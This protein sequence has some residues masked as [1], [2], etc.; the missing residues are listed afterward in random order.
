MS[1]VT[2]HVVHTLMAAAAGIA[3]TMASLIGGTSAAS[4]GFKFKTVVDTSTAVPRG[5]GALFG[6]TLGSAPAVSGNNVVFTANNEEIWTASTTGRGLVRVISPNMRIPGGHGATFHQDYGTFVQVHGD[7]VV[8]V[9]LDCSLCNSGM[10]LYAVPVAG[11]TVKRLVDVNLARPDNPEQNFGRFGDDFDA[12]GAHVVFAN[13]GGVYA[14]RVVGGR[15]NVVTDVANCTLGDY[16]GFGLPTLDSLDSE[17][18]LKASNGLS[19]GRIELARRAG[20][21]ITIVADGAMHPPNTPRAYRFDEFFGSFD[22]P[23]IDRSADHNNRVFKGESA[24]AS[25]PRIYGIYNF[26]SAGHIGLV[27]STTPVPG[28]TGAFSGSGFVGPGARSLAAGNGIVI[29]RGI[30]ATGKLG[31]YAV[32]ASGGAITK[33][34]AQGDPIN[35]TTVDTAEPQSLVF[36]REGFDGTTLVFVA[37]YAGN[38][39]RG[40]FST[41][42]V[43]P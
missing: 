34:I 42:V 5:G 9:G 30:D 12:N 3:L 21:L 32:R 10:G 11:G 41:Q 1:K 28:G 18:L 26:G 31:I 22:L 29:F 7:T 25:A 27:D 23:V 14:V 39:G 8:L 15:S 43:L 37:Q 17:V 38:T 6:L 2:R 24:A 33:I 40:V 13:S 4:A 36:R 16:C 35:G 19:N 20:G